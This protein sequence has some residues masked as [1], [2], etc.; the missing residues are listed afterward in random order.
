VVGFCFALHLTQIAN[1]H[2][3]SQ[4]LRH[5]ALAAAA[6]ASALQYGSLVG[7]Q[8][9]QQHGS[10]PLGPHSGN[11]VYTAAPAADCGGM[12]R[13]SSSSSSD[14]NGMARH[15]VSCW[16]DHCMSNVYMFVVQ[17]NMQRCI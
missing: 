17:L 14:G 5:S 15:K 13:G 2:C 3:A 12:Q 11:M 16:Y 6:P 8:Q 10:K 7:E 1:M 9:Q 4:L